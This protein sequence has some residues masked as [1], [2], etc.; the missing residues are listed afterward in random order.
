MTER[1]IDDPNHLANM[2][3]LSAQVDIQFS[4]SASPATVG[5]VAMLTIGVVEFAE[6]L[7]L[8]TRT[9]YESYPEEERPKD[10]ELA[11]DRINLG[12]NGI[13]RAIWAVAARHGLA[14]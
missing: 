5:D 11:L 10:I 1:L 8:I 14:P 6:A 9:L 13:A 2:R 7:F 4:N 12:Y 3:K